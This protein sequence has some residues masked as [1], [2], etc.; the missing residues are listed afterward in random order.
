MTAGLSEEFDAWET[1]PGLVTALLP[2]EL[3]ALPEHP[4]RAAERSLR[5]VADD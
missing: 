2:G 5:L 1:N 3:D 4:E